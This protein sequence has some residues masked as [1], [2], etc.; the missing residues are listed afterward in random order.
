VVKTE[1][2]WLWTASKNKLGYGTQKLMPDVFL[3][4]R[5]SWL[6]NKGQI[7][8]GLCVL[9]RCDVPACVN[10]DH[11]FLG[12]NK[13]NVDDKMK[14]RRHNSGKGEH[15]GVSK[16]K[17]EQVLEIRKMFASGT[18]RQVI[19]NK[20]SITWENVHSIVTRKTWREI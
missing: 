16:L 6:I 3:A 13:D 2:C 4:H 5:V 12:T 10:P 15:H 9:H 14:K 17:N 8:V 11:L 18:P 19:A 20:F 7:P 1:S